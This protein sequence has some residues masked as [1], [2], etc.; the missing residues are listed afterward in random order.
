M[1]QAVFQTDAIYTDVWF[2][3]GDDQSV[4]QSRIEQLLPYQVNEN[5]NNYNESR[6]YRIACLPA[7]HDLNTEVGQKY[8]SNLALPKWKLQTK[9][10]EA[11]I[12]L[13]LIK[14]KTDYIL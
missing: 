10:L 13:F 4:Y 1:Q 12:Q 2:S 9:C 5:A 6:C 14:R 8:M 3:M 7:F 11:I